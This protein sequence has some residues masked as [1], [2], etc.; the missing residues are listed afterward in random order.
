MAP[1]LSTSLYT[2]KSQKNVHQE[3]KNKE[4]ISDQNL[5][6]SK[7]YEWKIVWK[8]VILFIYFHIGALYGFYL[9]C[10]GTKKYT[11]LW[12]FVMG[13]AGS[14]G[15]TA[16]AHRLWSHR[17]YKAKWPLR[18]LLMLLQT[19]SHQNHI[20]EWVRD[21]RV[22]H[23]F[24]DTDADPHNAH[25][26]FFFSHIG[27]LLVRKHSDVIKKGATVDMSDLEKDPIVVFQ[28][29]LFY[30]LMPLLCFVIPVGVPCYFWNE[31][32]INSWYNN[33][34]RYVFCLNMTWLVNSAAHMWGMR[35]Y[36]VNIGPTEN[37]IVSMLVCGEGWH[38]Y[39]HVFPWDYKAAELGG[40]KTNLTTAFID[41]CALL[42]Q[43]YDLKT[44][45][46]EMIAKRIA[47]TG[48]GSSYNKNKI[49]HHY[50]DMKWGWGDEDMKPHEIE[51][52]RIYNKKD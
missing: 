11:I 10:N 33:L 9:W 21:H 7:K 32:F 1:N 28:R 47:R 40:Y 2:K 19:L 29:R 24:T 12:F 45:S 25:R 36:D 35:P 43:A 30:V 20:Y 27:W 37:L 26:G 14:M 16:G 4:K 18:F 49:I 23:K 8:N 3:K 34:A 52:I 6:N 41:F 46:E 13:F 5:S 38:N 22:H 48:S 50:E 39:H 42:G 17:A 44:V 31:Q 51:E 15:V